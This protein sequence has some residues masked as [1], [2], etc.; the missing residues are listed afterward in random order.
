MHPTNSIRRN[1]NQLRPAYSLLEVLLALAL[2]VV[3][4]A[5]IAMAIR[6]NL[7]ALTH[8]Q[9]LIERKQIA[10]S[11]L[12]MLSNDL[13]AG[14]QYKATDYSGLENLIKTQQLTM[15][16]LAAAVPGAAAEPAAEEEEEPIVNEED[17]SFR[18]TLLGSSSVLMIDISR[19]PRVDQYNPLIASA[20]SLMQSPSDVKSIAYFVSNVQGG[21]E[22]EIEF[23]TAAQGGLYRRE[24]D[25]AVAS[26]AGDTGMVSEPDSF[27][28][29]VAAEI[30]QITFRYFD[31]TDWLDDWDSAEN[32][33]FPPAI[34][35]IVVID[36][37]RISKSNTTYSYN[38]FDQETMETYRTVVHL[39]VAEVPE[40]E[41]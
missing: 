12:G 16:S 13:R 39:P 38:G 3:V 35:I 19:L 32:G 2:S 37:S 31:G 18:P 6:V 27:S 23:E 8:Q 10:R 4:F 36:P 21:S 29:L 22:S 34:E 33:G 15:G 24:V 30:A 11:V 5:A 1:S 41:E 9:A 20:A 17:V 7:V 25:R 28:Q 40:E 14:I 26:Y